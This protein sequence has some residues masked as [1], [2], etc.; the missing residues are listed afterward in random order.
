MGF[1]N[2]AYARVFFANDMGKYSVANLSVSK[3]DKATNQ[4]KNEFQHGVVRFVGPAHDKLKS[5]RLPTKEQFKKGTDK[6]AKIQ[7]TSCDVTNNYVA[8]KKATYW[9]C[10]V[11]DFENAGNESGG[12]YKS[13]P[14]AGVAKSAQPKTVTDDD[15]EQLP[16]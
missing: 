9:N 14:N 1:R 11:F 2:G 3:L 5:L 15:E 8:E 12:G 16:F 10:T 6:G 7:I 4:Y 13:N